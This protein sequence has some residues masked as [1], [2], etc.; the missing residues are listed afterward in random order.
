ME[1]AKVTARVA[2][3]VPTYK[4]RERL[5]SAI[6][7]ILAQT[8]QDFVIVVVDDGG[9]LPDLP[10]DPRL[11][12]VSLSKNVGIAGVAPKRWNKAE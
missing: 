3:I 2:C 1:F 10:K 6:E 9:G 7:S 8:F 4:R 12:A 5:V 11:T